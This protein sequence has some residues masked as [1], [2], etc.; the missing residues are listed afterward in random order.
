MA[1]GWTRWF[2]L[3][4]RGGEDWDLV[5]TNAR[6]VLYA[7]A[8][9]DAGSCRRRP[10]RAPRRPGG[11]ICARLLAHLAKLDVLAVDERM[12]GSLLGGLDAR[13]DGWRG[14]D[15]T[16]AAYLA[17]LHEAGVGEPRRRR[18]P[19]RAAGLGSPASTGRSAA[20]RSGDPRRGPRRP[21]TVRRLH[22]G[23]GVRVRRRR[24]RAADEGLAVARWSPRR[25]A[26]HRWRAEGATSPCAR[27]RAVFR[28]LGP[29][30][31]GRTLGSRDRLSRHSLGVVVT[32]SVLPAVSGRGGD[33][34]TQWDPLVTNAKPIK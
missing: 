32:R 4:A 33:S 13:L 1:S 18:W 25:L 27:G 19:R 6:C 23:R 22:R 7:T 21:A 12:L 2:G 17:E 29:Q 16:L 28:R 24:S 3:F 10:P 15:A 34:L 20:D 14:E 5:G 30:P 8:G 26:R 31:W 11:I 9:A